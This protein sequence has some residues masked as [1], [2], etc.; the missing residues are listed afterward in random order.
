MTPP[1][2]EF[3]TNVAELD[4]YAAQLPQVADALRSPVA[5]LTEHTA[6]QRPMEVAA[7]SAMERTYGALTDDIA[8]RQRTMCDR[9]A[10]TAEALGEIAAVYRR[11]DGQG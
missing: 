2:Q 7:V 8:A 1:G 9:I 6:T 4:R 5:T 11:V 3:V 10:A